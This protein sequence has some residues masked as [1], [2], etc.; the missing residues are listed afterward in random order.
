[1]TVV[2]KATDPLRREC[3][4]SKQRWNDKILRD[5]PKQSLE[6]VRRCITD[7]DWIAL[8]ADYP[9]RRAIYRHRFTLRHSGRR[10]YFK[11]VIELS[12]NDPARA[13]IRTAFSTAR[14]KTEEKME[15]LKGQSS[16]PRS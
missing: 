12:K 14:T 13:E 6:W 8:D 4:L 16:K 2:L 9:N 7:P 1:M 15:W 10:V 3:R 5:H 11:V